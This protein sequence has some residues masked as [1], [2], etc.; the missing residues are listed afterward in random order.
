MQVTCKAKYNV[1][2][3]IVEGYPRTYMV[4]VEWSKSSASLLDPPPTN[5]RTEIQAQ[6]VLGKNMATQT[7]YRQLTVLKSVIKGL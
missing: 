1:A 7:L 6:V 5:A 4:D 3:K 2:D